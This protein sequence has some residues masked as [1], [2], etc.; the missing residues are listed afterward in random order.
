MMVS[1]MSST[2]PRMHAL[3]LASPGVVSVAFLP[4]L[5]GE[6]FFAQIGIAADAVAMLQGWQHECAP[7]GSTLARVPPGTFKFTFMFYGN[8]G[9]TH[10]RRPRGN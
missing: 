5:P 3:L 6:A 7:P 2:L 4:L 9:Q 1:F 10:V 8:H